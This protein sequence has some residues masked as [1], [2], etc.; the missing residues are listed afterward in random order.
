MTITSAKLAVDEQAQFERIVAGQARFEADRALFEQA[1]DHQAATARAGQQPTP[2]GQATVNEDAGEVEQPGDD[3]EARFQRDVVPYM[4]QLYPAA[5]RMT[6]NPTDAEDLVQETITKA[7]RAFHQFQP[8]TNLKAWLYRIMTNTRNSAYRKQSRQPLQSLYGDLEDIP[9]QTGPQAKVV[10]SAEAA[11]LERLPDSEVLTAL[12][13][14]PEVF[15]TVVYMADVE[16]YAYK[17]IAD[18]MA[19]PIGTVMSRLHRGRQRLR[20]KLAAYAPA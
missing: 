12:R 18:R 20:T 6:S 7:Y 4:Q 9:V 2:A 15:R 19:V 10:E 5:L 11:A 17:E 14:L 16:G 13:E 8:G 1:M 3:Q